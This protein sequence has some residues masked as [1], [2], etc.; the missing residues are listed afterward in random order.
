[1]YRA[2]DGGQREWKFFF[3]FDERVSNQKSLSNIPLT[4]LTQWSAES[5]QILPI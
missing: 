1:M 2:A 3:R 5:Q 4:Q